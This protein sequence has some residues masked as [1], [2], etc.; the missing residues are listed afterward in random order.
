M[1]VNW[2]SGRPGDQWNTG[3][4]GRERAGEDAEEQ[5]VFLNAIIGTITFYNV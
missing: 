5:S 4:S 3:E 1:R 2:G